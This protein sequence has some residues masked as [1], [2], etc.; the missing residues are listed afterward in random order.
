MPN[1][2]NPSNLGQIFNLSDAVNIIPNNWGLLQQLGIFE[3]HFSDQKTV[4]IPRTVYDQALI[5]DRN[6]DERNSASRG[7]T[8]SYLTAAIPHF[9]LDDYITPQDLDGK[10]AF[11]DIYQGVGLESLEA[12]RARKMVQIRQ[13]HSLTLE[14]ARAQ[15]ITTGSVYAPSGTLTQS[16]GSTIN[17]YNEF[18][19]TRTEL[20]FTLSDETTNPLTFVEPALAGIQDGLQSGEIVNDFVVLASPTFFNALVTHPYVID[21]YKYY[22]QTQGQQVVT[23]R[24]TADALGLDARYRTF[25]FGGMLFVEYRGN[26]TDRNTGTT[27]AFI[28]AGDA[29]AFPVTATNMFKTYFAPPNRFDTINQMAKESYFFEYMG[30]KQDKIEIE[31]ESNFMNAV[32]RPKALVRLYA[33]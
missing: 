25:R 16:Y 33:N 32:M 18:G 4:F 22:Q 5:P 31:T 29:Y 30:L 21:A 24:L 3:N 20:A 9:P 19:V 15:L 13:A 6:W 23:G 10:A 7:P 26:Y 17:W 27:T 11:S 14:A 2:Y 28:P 1:V 8:R 12:T